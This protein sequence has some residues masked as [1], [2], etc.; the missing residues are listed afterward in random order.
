MK[1]LHSVLGV[2]TAWC[3]PIASTAIR[4]FSVKQNW[5]FIRGAGDWDCICQKCRPH[6]TLRGMDVH[7]VLSTGMP[8]AAKPPRI[9]AMRP[10]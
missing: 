8:V 3:H 5:V 9:L 2:L 7:F 10:T 6:V 4:S 1:S